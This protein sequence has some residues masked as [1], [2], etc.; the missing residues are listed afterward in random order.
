V[1]AVVALAFGVGGVV[2]LH[3]DINTQSSQEQTAISRLQA[4]NQKLASEVAKDHAAL[5][6]LK[7]PAQVN[8]GQM[9]ICYD[10]STESFSN[11][12]DSIMDGYNF[13]DGVD[14]ESPNLL[15]G[16][17]SCPSGDSFVPVIPGKNS[18]NGNS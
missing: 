14:I 1:V 6:G 8:T 2:K 9:G 5:S 16:V 3:A 11:L 17:V 13:V 18:S 12:D 7:V 10:T 15:N 4:A